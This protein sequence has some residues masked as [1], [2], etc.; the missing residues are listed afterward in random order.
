MVLH[1]RIKVTVSEGLVELEGEVE[2]QFQKNAA[3]NMVRYLTGARNVSNR[4]TVRPR[5]SEDELEA[6]SRMPSSATSIPTPIASP[7]RPTAAK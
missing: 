6:G 1:D 5:V 2:W 7:S 3:E 4:I